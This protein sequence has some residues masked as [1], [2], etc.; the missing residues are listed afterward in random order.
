MRAQLSAA[1]SNSQFDSSDVFNSSFLSSH[2]QNI[3]QNGVQ[4]PIG[5]SY[6]QAAEILNGSDPDLNSNSS[7]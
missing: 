1:I 2:A 5:T 7:M 6:N 4:N 3:C